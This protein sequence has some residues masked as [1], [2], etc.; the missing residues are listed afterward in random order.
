MDLKK[1]CALISSTPAARQPIL[2]AG[3]MQDYHKV[4]STDLGIAVVL[5]T[6][7]LAQELLEDVSGLNGEFLRDRDLFI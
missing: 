6:Y 1:G 2:S 3:C 7:V 5:L 4:M